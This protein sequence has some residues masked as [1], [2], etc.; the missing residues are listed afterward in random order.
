MTKINLNRK[1]EP[2][3]SNTPA[4]KKTDIIAHLAEVA[5]WQ[6]D[7]QKKCIHKKYTFENYYAT[8]A[9]MN[10]VAWIAHSE[11]HHPDCA[12]SYQSCRITLKTHA[13]DGLSANDFILAHKINCLE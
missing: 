8:M 7:E 13:I 1:C 4:L 6:W 3:S 12:V 5:G 9:F 10:A 2:C 11:N